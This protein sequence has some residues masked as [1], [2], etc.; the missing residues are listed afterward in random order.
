MDI[1]NTDSSYTIQLGVFTNPINNFKSLD[2]IWIEQSYNIYTFYHGQFINANDA[3]KSL[4][5]LIQLGYRNMHI[6]KKKNKK[7]VTK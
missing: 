6:I 4:N 5:K 2:K 3:T 7:N 1:T